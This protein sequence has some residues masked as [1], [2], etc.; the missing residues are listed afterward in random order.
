MLS[1]IPLLPHS[2]NASIMYNY[3][4]R[5]LDTTNGGLIGV[6]LD[7]LEVLCVVRHLQE[8]HFPSYSLKELYTI[9]REEMSYGS[10]K[11]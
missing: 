3:I 4:M 10:T 8:K 2:Y 5:K 7:T 1:S 9:L 6:D 11:R